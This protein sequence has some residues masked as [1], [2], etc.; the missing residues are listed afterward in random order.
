MTTLIVRKMNDP[1]P[2]PVPAP[3]HNCPACAARAKNHRGPRARKEVD[4]WRRPVV[5][6]RIKELGRRVKWIREQLQMDQGQMAD[7]CGTSRSAVGEIE[8][9]VPKDVAYPMAIADGVGCPFYRLFWPKEKWDRYVAE[10]IGKFEAR[11]AALIRQLQ[12]PSKP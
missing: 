2:P 5:Q 8:R 1:E 6:E 4:E 12:P 10:N 11:R 7:L 3:P 9:G